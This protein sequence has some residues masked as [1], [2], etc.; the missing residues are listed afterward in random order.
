MLLIIDHRSQ[1]RCSLADGWMKCYMAQLHTFDNLLA[2]NILLL[3]W[4]DKTS[5]K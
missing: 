3:L 1:G 4:G 2:E 5:Y